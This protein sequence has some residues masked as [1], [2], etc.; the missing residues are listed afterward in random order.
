MTKSTQVV[1]TGKAVAKGVVHGQFDRATGR[2]DES[3]Q[4]FKG[5]AAG[6][7]ESLAE[8]IRE[9]GDQFEHGGEANAIARRLEKTADYIR[10][11]P[12]SDVAA[13]AWDITKRYHLLW[14]AGGLLAGVVAIRL[15]TRARHEKS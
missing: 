14:W 13:D 12:T 10:Y 7:I 4:K 3:T 11:R 2:F 5:A 8:Q 15:A 1:E 9:L 6:K